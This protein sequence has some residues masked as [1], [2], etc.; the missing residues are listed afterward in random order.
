MQLNI[1]PQQPWESYSDWGTR[2]HMLF[3]QQATV[4]KKTVAFTVV[5]EHGYNEVT[6]QPTFATIRLAPPFFSVANPIMWP[7]VVVLCVVLTTLISIVLHVV[8]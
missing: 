6:V 7:T 1:L 4:P 8:R 3:E 2:L 5:R